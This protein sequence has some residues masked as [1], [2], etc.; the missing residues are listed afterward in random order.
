MSH[1]KE[2]V[3]LIKNNCFNITHTHHTKTEVFHY[4]FGQ[5]YLIN[6]TEKLCFLYSDNFD[7]IHQL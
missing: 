2:V 6:F 1:A 3:K 5:T 7:G 4:R